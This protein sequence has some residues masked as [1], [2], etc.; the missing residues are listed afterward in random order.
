MD[1]NNF[2]RNLLLLQNHYL[3]KSLDE[4]NFLDEI[5]F[6]AKSYLVTFGWNFFFEEI[7]FGRKVFWS[8]FFFVAKYFFKSSLDE[9]NLVEIFLLQNHFLRK[10][11]DEKNFGRKFLGRTF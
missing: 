8:N 5:F 9:K 3:G 4:M 11:L 6:V 2:G 7:D 10:I 1:E